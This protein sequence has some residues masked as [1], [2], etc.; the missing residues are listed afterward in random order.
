MWTRTDPYLEEYKSETAVVQRFHAEEGSEWPLLSINI[1]YPWHDSNKGIK[2]GIN[3]K[4]GAEHWWEET[5]LPMELL[6][7]LIDML[8]QV[9]NVRE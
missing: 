5:S 9:K 4:T 8:N 6:P 1:Y 2:I 7:E 3:R